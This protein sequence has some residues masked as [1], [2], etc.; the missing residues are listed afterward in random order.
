[1]VQSLFATQ[2]DA[3]VRGTNERM[4]A[5]IRKSAERVIKVMQE[6]VG[7]GGA[8]PIDTGF[9][10]SSLKVMPGNVASLPAVKADGISVSYNGG[11]AVMV[12]SN[13]Q[14]GESITAIYV[15]N[16][17]RR[18][19]YGFVGEDSLGRTYN[20]KGRHFVDRAAQQWPSIVAGVTAELKASAQ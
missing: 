17:A 10:Q 7:A 8:M 20:Q 15:A 9:L 1:M 13:M 2:V 3:W 12:I 18:V 19:N 6:P 14:P 5:V 11:A 4:T 16:Y